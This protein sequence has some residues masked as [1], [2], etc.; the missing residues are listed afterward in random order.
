MLI[1][2]T[3][4]M[5]GCVALAGSGGSSHATS[6]LVA[7]VIILVVALLVTSN[8]TQPNPLLLV[9]HTTDF[10]WCGVAWRGDIQAMA[11]VLYR[12]IKRLNADDSRYGQLTDADDQSK[13]RAP[14]SAAAG[15]A[16]HSAAADHGAAAKLAAAVGDNV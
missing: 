12:K 15:G 16:D 2:L 4:W 7:F 14:P 5:D 1:I 13:R 10:V 9:V 11:V 6:I 8:P 3:C